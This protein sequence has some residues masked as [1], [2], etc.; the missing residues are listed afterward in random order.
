MYL[1]GSALKRSSLANGP[2][3]QAGSGSGGKHRGRKVK[4]SAGEPARAQA[5]LFF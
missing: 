1:Q 2:Q 4:S 3:V 5:K